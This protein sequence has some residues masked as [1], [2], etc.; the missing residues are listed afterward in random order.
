ML[1][2]LLLALA[3][4]AY[5]EDHAGTITAASADCSTANSCVSVT[6][7]PD[8][9]GTIRLQL[10]AT[11]AGTVNFEGTSNMVTWV[12]MLGQVPGTGAS[13][14]STTGNGL[15][16]FP[17]SGLRGFRARGHV[18]SSGLVEVAII[19]STAGGFNLGGAGGVSIYGFVST[20]SANN[21]LIAT[22]ARTLFGLMV[23]NPTASVQYIRLYDKA[24]A[25]DPSGCS[26]NT[27]CPV[28][29]QIIPTQGATVNGS[30]WVLPI[31][32]EGVAFA[33]G[34]GYSI[35]GAA[36]TV[37]STCVDE[38]NAL[39]GVTVTFIYK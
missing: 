30:G 32:S 5:A 11:W 37:M 36:C 1:L 23:T 10:S 3:G 12:A 2:V 34:L 33:N 4:A 17:A 26:G 9:I 38:T 24:T 18:Y 39:A 20:A 28:M 15:W 14:T 7:L 16:V 6:S 35:T 25:P 29:Y 19:T 31:P 22:G 27:D 13:A 21:T 8:K